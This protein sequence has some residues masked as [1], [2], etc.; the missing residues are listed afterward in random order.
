MKYPYCLINYYKAA[1]NIKKTKHDDRHFHMRT[2]EY[3]PQY[4]EIQRD[5]PDAHDGIV[6]G[7]P[8]P[9]SVRIGE[10]AP[11]DE[12]TALLEFVEQKQDTKNG[13][14][15]LQDGPPFRIADDPV[16]PADRKQ[17]DA[18]EKQGLERHEIPEKETAFD[19]HVIKQAL[20]FLHEEG[21]F[22]HFYKQPEIHPEH[23]GKDD[24]QQQQQRE[25]HIIHQLP[26]P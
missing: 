4:R 2:D 22:Y 1:Q 14:D 23:K 16:Y 10:Y 12:I 6:A 8:Q 15:R 25:D 7:F 19:C 11:E 3:Q 9:I 13:A 18:R 20:P 5:A 17:S 24:E 21:V 26:V